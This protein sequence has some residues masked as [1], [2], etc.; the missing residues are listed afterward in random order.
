MSALSFLNPL[1]AWGAALAL[2]PLLI[3]L[4]NRRRARPIEFAAIDFI[5]RSRRKT[6]RRLRLRRILLFAARTLILIAIPLALARPL[7]QRAPETTAPEGPAATAI[8]LDTSLSMS[9]EQGG[10][11]LLARGREL[12]ME[13]LKE[14]TPEEPVTFVDCDPKAPPPLAPGFDRAAVRDAIERAAQ[15][16]APQSLNGCLARASKALSESPVA[17]KRLYVISDLTAASIR[18]D[19]PPPTISTPQGE[20]RPRVVLLDAAKGAKE[21]PNSAVTGLRVEPAPGQGARAYQFIATLANHGEAAIGEAAISLRVGN[22]VVAKSFAELPARGSATRALTYKFPVGGSFSGA[23][24]LA[25]DALA[26]DD[27][28][29]FSLT[30]PRE[31]RALVVDGAPHPSRMLDEVFFVEAALTAPG[32]SVVPKVVDAQGCEAESLESYDV[33]LLLNVRE[34]SEAKVAELAARVRAGAGL[35]ISMGDQIDVDLFNERFASLSP[36][37]LHVLKTA[38]TRGE[39][40]ADERAARFS[41]VEFDHPTFQ[42][43]SGEARE[44]LLSVRTWRY[45]LFAP[46]PV[47]QGESGEGAVQALASFDDGAPALLT[48][49]LGKGR[50]ALFAT[51]VDRDWSDFAIRTSFLPEMQRLSAWLAGALDERVLEQVLVGEERRLVPPEGTKLLSVRRPDREVRSASEVPGE[52]GHFAFS[53][54]AAPGLYTVTARAGGAP[55]ERPELNFAVNVEPSESDLARVEVEEL[56][57]W[58]GEGSRVETQGDTA[59]QAQAGFPLWSALL[60]A[61][62]ALF[63]CEGLLARR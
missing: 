46:A 6:A 43:F 19:E 53:E 37:P 62:V 18:L 38:A 56:T 52:P 30:V 3:H 44:G 33:V 17:A 45:Y 47:G 20:V 50:V 16:F 32:S 1:L 31:V 9:Y 48:R 14:L 8:L 15:R 22:E 60:M 28:R 21:L 12:A 29:Y 54:T 26:L 40:G 57:A 7:R 25:G 42:V 61:A 11:S 34:L 13:A 4:F 27:K 58:L 59:E 63:L 55:Q 39:P 35:F 2:L 23:L 10:E 51:T 24:E 5:L 49:K 41:Q 36:R